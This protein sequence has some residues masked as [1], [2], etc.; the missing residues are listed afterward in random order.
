[1]VAK[2]AADTGEGH[3]AHGSGSSGCSSA[4]SRAFACIFF[5]LAA[6]ARLHKLF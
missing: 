4:N 3:A 6:V 2:P 5:T 1:M